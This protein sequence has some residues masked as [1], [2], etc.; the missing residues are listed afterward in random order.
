MDLF[1]FLTVLTY[2][3]KKKTGA[4]IKNELPIPV[5]KETFIG[6]KHCPPEFSGLVDLLSILSTENDGEAGVG[7][8]VYVGVT[9]GVGEYVG[10]AVFV[11]VAVG[12]FVGVAV[13]VGVGVEVFVGVGVNVAVGLGVGVNVGTP[14]KIKSKFLFIE[15]LI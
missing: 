5:A 9:V 2:P 12:T 11:E 6:P 8:D 15:P 14:I 3:A 10:V 4:N 7:V 13:L 1:F